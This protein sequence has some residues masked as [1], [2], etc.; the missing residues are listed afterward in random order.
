MLAAAL[1]QNACAGDLFGN[2]RRLFANSFLP[3]LSRFEKARIETTLR[4]FHLRADTFPA[5]K[6]EHD[7]SDAGLY[8]DVAVRDP[9]EIPGFRDSSR[10]VGGV[11][12][13]M[14]EFPAF[15]NGEVALRIV[16]KFGSHASTE[17]IH[18]I[19]KDIEALIR[20]CENA[21]V[22]SPRNER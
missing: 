4:G 7:P 16:F 6:Q 13:R 5:F 22:G 2:P 21:R 15:E 17:A 11:T 10:M 8:L 3:V 1:F 14:V 12:E 19:G 20:E 18:A 9:E